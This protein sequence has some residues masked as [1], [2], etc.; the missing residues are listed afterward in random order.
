MMSTI[1]GVRSIV[2]DGTLY[3]NDALHSHPLMDGLLAY[4]PAGMNIENLCVNPR[5]PGRICV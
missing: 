4:I 5:V 1:Y 3:L 2:P